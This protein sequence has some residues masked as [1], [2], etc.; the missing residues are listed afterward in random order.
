MVLLHA[1]VNDDLFD[2][3]KIFDRIKQRQMHAKAVA[4][5]NL[6]LPL[7]YQFFCKVSLQNFL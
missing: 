3:F 7:G 4:L 1:D 6:P 2:E 5:E